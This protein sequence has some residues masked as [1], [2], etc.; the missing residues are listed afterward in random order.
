MPALIRGMRHRRTREKVMETMSKGNYV[1][2]TREPIGGDRRPRRQ[3]DL[4]RIK[5]NGKGRENMVM[6]RGNRN[7]ASPS[8]IVTCVYYVSLH[9]FCAI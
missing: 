3:W 6:E 2:G 5:E 8:Y 4:T 7:N 1:I 9:L